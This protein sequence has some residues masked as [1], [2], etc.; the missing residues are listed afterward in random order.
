[1]CGEAAQLTFVRAIPNGGENGAAQSL[2]MS[3]SSIEFR[4]QVKPVRRMRHSS[5]ISNSILA[6]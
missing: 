6:D 4:L 5:E 2:A 1:M 3:L